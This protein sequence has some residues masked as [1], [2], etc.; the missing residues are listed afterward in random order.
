[1]SKEPASIWTQPSVIEKTKYN[2][3]KLVNDTTPQKIKEHV[4]DMLISDRNY[5]EFL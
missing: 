3:D 1:M 4:I 2:Y 5:K